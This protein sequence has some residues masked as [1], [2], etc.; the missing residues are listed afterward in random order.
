VSAVDFDSV[1]SRFLR[2]QRGRYEGVANILE[3]RHSGGSPAGFALRQQTGRPERRSLW[4]R[5]DAMIHALPEIFCVAQRRPTGLSPSPR[6]RR[7]YEATLQRHIP[8][9]EWLE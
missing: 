4:K 6:H 5:P 3:F 7:H 2:R 8:Y 1:E 9:R